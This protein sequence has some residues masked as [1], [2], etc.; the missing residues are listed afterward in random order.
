MNGDVTVSDLEDVLVRKY[1]RLSAR[2]RDAA[3]YLRA[4]QIDVA[5]RSLRVISEQSGIAP[6]TFSR[7]ARALEFEDYEAM[8]EVLRRALGRKSPSLS[9]RVAALQASADAE[10]S[11]PF[12]HRQS[13]ACA[14]NIRALAQTLD[15]TR[16]DRC[17]ELLDKAPQVVVAGALS[18]RGIAE[19]AAYLGHYVSPRWRVLAQPGTSIAADVSD[20]GDGDVLLA[21]TMAP[22]AASSLA[23]AEHAAAAGAH[24]VVITDTLHC[25]ALG[26]AGISL[27]VPTGSPQFFS[28]Y[29]AALVLIET[30]IGMLV[31]RRGPAAQVRISRIETLGGALGETRRPD[32]RMTVNQQGESR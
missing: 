16:L 25:P 6:A 17:V 18:S 31:A 15:L 27:V 20:L 22:F 32:T 7:L 11:A 4:H 19:Y 29:A 14:A 8:R 1:A 10:G 9:D 13:E 23:A 5:T 21:I 30:L 24:V 3:D 2:L 26:H 12:L 28:S